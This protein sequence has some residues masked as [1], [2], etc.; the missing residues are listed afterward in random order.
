[1]ASG[2][3]VVTTDL[4]G[5]AEAVRHEWTGLLVPQR[6]PA[7]LAD[8]IDRLL[9][10]PE[11]AASLAYEARRHVERSFSLDRNTALLRSLF[12]EVC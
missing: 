12:P 1:M 10:S 5:L 6:D 2:V 9:A 3:P 7:A 8:A 4:D 11:L